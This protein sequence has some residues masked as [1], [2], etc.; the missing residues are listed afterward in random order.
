MN[1][2]ST[3]E[4][5]AAH[6]VCARSSQGAAHQPPSTQ[7]HKPCDELLV[8]LPIHCLQLWTQMGIE[9]FQLP[10]HFWFGGP[11]V[12]QCYALGHSIDNV[13]NLLVVPTERESLD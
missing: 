9:A 11:F 10:M 3:R 12:Q 8:R 2:T 5:L 7:L 4:M 1:R 6:R 13:C